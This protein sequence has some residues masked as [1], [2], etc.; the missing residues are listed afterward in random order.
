MIVDDFRNIISQLQDEV[1]DLKK[2]ISQLESK[3]GSWLD[4][5]FK[6]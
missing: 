4:R 2:R 5:V 6:N 1:S 3:Q